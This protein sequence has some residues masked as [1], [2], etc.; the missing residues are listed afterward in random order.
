VHRSG[1][2]DAK[3]TGMTERFRARLVNEPFGDPALYVEFA[4]E[5]RALLFDLGT[6]EPLTTRQLL[7]VT[8]VFVTHAHMDHFI[9][10]DRLLRGCLRQN[11]RVQLFGPPPF[12][13]Q[14][15][16]RLSA[17]TWN[18]LPGY[19]TDL[20]LVAIELGADGHGRAATFRGHTAFAR[21]AERTMRFTEA[22]LLDE[23][24][25]VV[26]AA[27]LDHKIPSLAF[28]L[29]ER[30]HVNIRKGGL[31]ALGLPAGSW[32]VDLKRAVASEAPDDH[33]I[34]V[35]WREGSVVRE[36]QY[37]L[38][39]LRELV[40]TTPGQKIAYVV[41]AVYHAANARAIVDLVHDA[42]LLFIEA[43]FLDQDASIAADRGHLTAGQAGRLAREA[44]VRRVV[45]F[46]FSPRY[47]GREDRLKSEVEAAFRSPRQP[48]VGSPPLPVPAVNTSRPRGA[49]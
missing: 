37:P 38:G 22:T 44:G 1:I 9:G 5:R 35:W 42:D 7:R 48:T 21:E 33:P 19:A 43:P 20:V 32:L 28:A 31:E 41:D 23:E 40:I 27:V 25:V 16:H 30:A 6:L 24:T 49:S 12:I 15:G 3:V 11:K 46:H 8:D 17:Y 26:R 18:L 34:R 36:R 47:V 39:A 10:F 29:E 45:P 4:F 13:E 2:L 14:V